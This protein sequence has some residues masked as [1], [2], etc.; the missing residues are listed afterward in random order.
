MRSGIKETAAVAIVA[1]LLVVFFRDIVIHGKTLFFYDVLMQNYP[2]RQYFAEGLRMGDFPLWCSH[3]YCGFPLFAES[4]GGPA[5]PVQM[6]LYLLLPDTAAFN[7]S[8]LL[9]LLLAGGG[10]YK[11]VRALGASPLPALLSAVTYTFSGALVMRLMHTNMVFGA[12]WLPVLLC[13]IELYFRTNRWRYL[14]LGGVAMGMVLLCSHPFVTTSTAIFASIYY[15]YRVIGGGA[16][17]ARPDTARVLRWCGLPI[18]MALGAALAAVQIL[19][20][21]ELI[22]LSSRGA[23]E[24]GFRVVGSLPPPNLFTLFVPGL[25]GNPALG[26]YRGEMGYEFFWESCCYVGIVPLMLATVAM[27]RRPDRASV[28]FGCAFFTALLLA[29]GS[30]SFLFEPIHT[31]PILEGQRLPS[32]YL[33]LAA[34]FLAVLAGLGLQ[35]ILVSRSGAARDVTGVLATLAVSAIV[36]GAVLALVLIGN[37]SLLTQDPATLTEG[38]AAVVVEIVYGAIWCAVLSALGLA[39]PTLYLKRLL[40][41]VPVAV[42]L[43]AVCFVDLFVFGSDFNPTVEPTLYRSP[44]ATV[45]AMDENPGPFRIFRTVA[46]NATGDPDEPRIDPFTPGWV[47]NEG[48]YLAATETLVPNSAMLFG[49]STVEGFGPLAPSRYLE[50]MGRQG[51]MGSRPALRVNGAI[52]DLCNVRYVISDR[53]L[54]LDTLAA[55]EHL[56]DTGL[57]V[58]RNTTALPRAYLVPTFRVMPAEDVL[59]TIRGAAL[60]PSQEVLLEQ[61]P[62][63]WTGQAAPDPTPFGADQVVIEQ[64][65]SDDVAVTTRADRPAIL[66]FSDSDYP[67]WQVTVD[68]EAAQLLRANYLFKAVAVPAGTHAVRFTFRSDSFRNGAAITGVAV[69]LLVILGVLFARRR[70]VAARTGDLETGLR[71][72]IAREQAGNFSRGL[73][74]AMLLLLLGSC[75]FYLSGSG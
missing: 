71:K 53:K 14:I 58:L 25:F 18:I 47:G 34:L 49:V 19:P 7:T 1:L 27:V 15:L 63:E 69:A 64:L 42:L 52:L 50:L 17:P 30:Y 65:S 38:E 72:A 10:T 11:L 6:L 43:I 37:S 35:K 44:P 13:F 51:Y 68:G 59:A 60:S 3:I 62:A 41:A 24:E 33:I 32:R 20:T 55:V 67:G 45:L 75:A 5:Y 70:W 74:L 4:Q 57:Y 9:H 2:F 23:P 66:V 16:S 39:L 46:E 12:A 48:R 8:V 26:S 56:P 40:G 21:I 31:L 28:F 36:I 29:L 22:S 54:S 73:L 61:A